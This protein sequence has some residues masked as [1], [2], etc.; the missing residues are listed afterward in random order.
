MNNHSQ[1]RCPLCDSGMVTRCVEDLVR[2]GNHTAIVCLETDVCGRCGERVYPSQ[3][4]R[5]FEDIRSKLARHDTTDFL[6]LGQTFRI[7]LRK[8]ARQRNDGVL[9]QRSVNADQHLTTGA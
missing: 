9:S 7:A 1:R 8:D 4:L 3:M 6:P 5:H 2:G